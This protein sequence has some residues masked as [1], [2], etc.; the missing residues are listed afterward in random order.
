MHVKKSNLIWMPLTRYR[1]LCEPWWVHHWRVIVI[2]AYLDESNMRE[3]IE[4]QSAFFPSTALSLSPQDAGGSDST[5]AH[6]VTNKHD[7]VLGNVHIQSRIKGL[8]QVLLSLLH[9]VVRI[10]KCNFP[11]R[12]TPMWVNQN[13]N[14]ALARCMNGPYY[15]A[16]SVGLYGGGGHLA[17]ALNT[18][19][20]EWH[21]DL[22][23]DLLYQNNHYGGGIRCD[24]CDISAFLIRSCEERQI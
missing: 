16:G 23:W 22:M 12:K 3:G 14:D 8:L 2:C 7:D 21:R 17:L 13:V 5:R 15:F 18:I 24:N 9:P 11:I 20:N 19:W 1:Y 4:G 10:C 6:T